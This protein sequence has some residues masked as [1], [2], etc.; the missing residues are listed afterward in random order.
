MIWIPALLVGSALILPLV[1]LAIR[2]FA[3]GESDVLDLLFRQRVAAILAR[4]VILV[5]SV[6]LASVILAVP[7]AWLTTRTDIPFRRAWVVLSVL[8]LVIPTYVA[9]FVVVAA[10][11]P[12]GML[13]N[14][15][16]AVF[17]IDRLPDI[18]GFSGA[19]LT[20][21]FLSFP[22]IVLTVRGKMLLIDPALE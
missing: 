21:T 11:G 19:F 12:K 3:T 7:L 16:E 18:H 6:T 2:T 9:G 10:L 1:Y 22:Y 17:G 14:A 20:L 4:T 13:Q 5:I 8:P 15:L